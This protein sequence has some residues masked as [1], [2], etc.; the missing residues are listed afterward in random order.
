MVI[1]SGRGIGGWLAYRRTRYEQS[2]RPQQK[3]TVLSGHHDGAT[4]MR[5]GQGN[6]LLLY[7]LQRACEGSSPVVL[8]CLQVVSASDLAGYGSN[9]GVLRAS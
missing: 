8:K 3:T 2:T 9:V 6:E 4:E 1:L 7:C 5:L